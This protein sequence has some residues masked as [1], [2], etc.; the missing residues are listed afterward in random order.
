[1][2]LSG[3]EAASLLGVAR[4]TTKPRLSPSTASVSI[5]YQRQAL[6]FHPAT[7]AEDTTYHMVKMRRKITHTWRRTAVGGGDMRIRLAINESE[8]EVERQITHRG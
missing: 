2:R 8:P 3:L 5:I 7:D 4:H 1:M 6:R